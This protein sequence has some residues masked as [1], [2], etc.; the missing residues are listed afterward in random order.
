MNYGIINNRRPD[1]NASS[2][3]PLL[4]DVRMREIAK[5]MGLEP[6][7]FDKEAQKIWSMLDDMAS[8]NP[9]AYQEFINDQLKDGPP[10]NQ[11]D[12]TTK[13]SFFTP[14]AG[15]VIKCVL[16]EPA[17]LKVFLN[18]CAHEIIDMPKNPNS[19][20]EV[21]A[22]TRK[23]PT[24]NNL[25]I[26]LVI[27]ALRDIHDC[28]GSTC[29]AVD[30]IFH[31]WVL[32]RCSWDSNFKREVL[33]LAMFWV[34]N[35][36]KV[37]FDIKAS[38]K[39]IKSRY[40][41]GVTI[42]NEIVTSKFHIEP[43]AGTG[44]TNRIRTETP[45][46]LLKQM[47]LRDQEQER[48]ESAIKLSRP[49]NQQQESARATEPKK[50]KLIEVIGSEQ[51][52]NQL[53]EERPQPAPSQVEPKELLRPVTTTKTTEPKPK[54]SSNVV[55]KGFLNSAKK[56]LYPSGSSEGRPAS[57]FVKLMSRSKVI[58][59]NE[60]ERQ[61][62][63]RSELEHERENMM[64]FLGKSG[65]NSTSSGEKDFGDYEFEQLCREADPDVEPAEHAEARRDPTRELFGDNWE[66]LGSLIT[67]K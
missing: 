22:D 9:K 8:K 1:K 38:G 25:Q 65:N 58:D 32:E 53:M 19:G 3:N 14:H 23:V 39:F 67:Q 4:A 54:K 11:N 64:S 42:G 46:D 18:V 17:G 35:D 41:G 48:E 57:A 63:E 44:L 12:G 29:R 6:K 43:D 34:Q 27:G 37:Q 26:P 59:M 30:V 62:K 7:D 50:K 10:T 60:V 49:S 66:R 40:K 20:Q 33:K 13:P 31:P 47:S 5:Q 52:D 61:K 45:T 36:T 16:L 15:F 55:K 56:P 2:I 21:L 28:N 51:H 24:T